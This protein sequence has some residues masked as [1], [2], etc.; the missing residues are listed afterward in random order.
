[1][2]YFTNTWVGLDNE[3][4][5]KLLKYA[6]ELWNCYNAV[7]N[8][9]PRTINGVEGW[10]CG[11]R[12]KVDESYANIWKFLKIIQN[13]QGIQEN[14]INNNY[15]GVQIK[16]RKR[17]YVELDQRL[18]SVV[19]NYKKTNVLSYLESIAVNVYFT[20]YKKSNIAQ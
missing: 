18:L 19:K 3:A 1:M 5:K 10:H 16:G 7:M 8:D 13:E 20:N 14:I 6:I 17:K 11:F 9:E 2:K 15:N 12:V 4:G